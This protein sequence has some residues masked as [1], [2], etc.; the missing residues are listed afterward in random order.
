MAADVIAQMEVHDA[1]KYREYASKVGATAAS[2]GGKFLA[3]NDADV[4]EGEPP[5]RRTIV[6][7][8]PS[9][10]K[11]NAWYDSEEYR[12][13]MPLR[14]ESTTSTVLFVEGFSLPPTEEESQG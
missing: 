9:L 11:A 12:K 8:F 2:Y 1:V 14:L 3:A 7:E 6:G 10:E 4:K 5:L 13:I